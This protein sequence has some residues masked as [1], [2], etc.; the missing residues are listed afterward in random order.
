MEGQV[1]R[2]RAD[3]YARAGITILGV[4]FDTPADNRAF[5]EAQGFPYLLLSDVDKRVGVA[6]GVLRDADDQYANFAKRMSF[7]IDPDGIVR[8][9]YTVADVAGHADVVLADH[10]ALVDTR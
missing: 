5:A 1:L 3:Q 4:S 6:Y 7:L 9:V 2:D 10:A 8:R